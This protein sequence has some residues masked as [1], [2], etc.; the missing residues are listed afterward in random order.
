M[1]VDLPVENN[2]QL[3]LSQFHGTWPFLK[4]GHGTWRLKNGHGKYFWSKNGH[5]HE[6]SI[7]FLFISFYVSRVVRIFL[8][9]C[10]YFFVQ[11]SKFYPHKYTKYLAHLKKK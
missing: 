3:W 10:A 1:E 11:S 7:I 5:G 8:Y 9:K 6:I 2:S 4:N